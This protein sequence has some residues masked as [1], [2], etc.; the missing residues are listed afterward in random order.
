MGGPAWCYPTVTGRGY[1]GKDIAGGWQIRRGGLHNG[2]DR[3]A[4][5]KMGKK[6]RGVPC[7]G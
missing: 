2:Q 3:A 7:R 4:V 1:G 5:R 6:G